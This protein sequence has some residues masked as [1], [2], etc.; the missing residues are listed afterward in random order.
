[1]KI[2]RMANLDGHDRGRFTEFAG[3]VDVDAARTAEFDKLEW[4]YKKRLLA[5]LL[6]RMSAKRRRVSN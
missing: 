6:R 2:M 5:A 4:R 1:M 3:H